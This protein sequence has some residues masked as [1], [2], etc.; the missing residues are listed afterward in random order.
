MRHRVRVYGVLG[1]LV[2]DVTGPGIDP[3]LLFNAAVGADASI[4]VGTHLQ[5]NG[6]PGQ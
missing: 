3:A 5:P 2:V 6:D 4:G 1:A